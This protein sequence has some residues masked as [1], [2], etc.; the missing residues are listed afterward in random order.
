MSTTLAHD[1]KSLRVFEAFEVDYHLPKW[2]HRM[3]QG[4][5]MMIYNNITRNK[6]GKLDVSSN[7]FITP[8]GWGNGVSIVGASGGHQQ[9]NKVGIIERIFGKSKRKKEAER[10]QQEQDL[11]QR[12]NMLSSSGKHHYPILWEL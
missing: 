3:E 11:A 1:K 6:D 10:R 7:T 2:K 8:I 9:D 4:A 5:H 12:P